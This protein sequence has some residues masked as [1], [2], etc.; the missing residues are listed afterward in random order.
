M[1]P[2]FVSSLG[3]AYLLFVSQV[4]TSDKYSEMTFSAL[5]RLLNYLKTKQVEDMNDK[6][7]NHLE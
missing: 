7:W 2:D 3:S 1:N 5:G 6:I 4:K